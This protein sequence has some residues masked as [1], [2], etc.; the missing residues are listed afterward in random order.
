MRKTSPLVALFMGL[1]YSV[2]AS[3]TDSLTVQNLGETEVHIGA[4]ITENLSNQVVSISEEAWV[5]KNFTAI[6]ILSSYGGIQGHK[7]GGIGS[8]QSISIRGASSRGVKIFIDGVPLEDAG[9]GAV[10]L[11]SID[12]NLVERIDVYKGYVPAF[13]GGNGIGGAIHFISK[14]RVNTG[15]QFSLSYGSHGLQ[16]AAVSFTIPLI[17][18]TRF[19]SSLAYRYSDNDYEFLNRNGTE[20]DTDD[21]FL[22][23]RKNA[24]YLQFSGNHT[25]YHTHENGGFSTLSFRHEKEKGGNPGKESNQTEVAGFNRDLGQVF[26]S[27]EP[28]PYKNLQFTMSLSGQIE[29]SVSHSY[30]PLDKIGFPN[31]YYMEYG[32]IRYF[33]QPKIIV[34]LPTDSSRSWA[35]SLYLA[36]SAERLEDRDNNEWISAYPWHLEQYVVEGASNIQW[37]LTRII[38]LELENAVKAFQNENSGGQWSLPIRNDSLIS[39]SN[40]DLLGSGRLAMHFGHL[41]SPW[42]ASLSLGRYFREPELMEQYGVYRNVLP[43]PDL[44]EET[45]WMGEISLSWKSAS[46]KTKLQSTYFETHQKNG[47]IWVTN[48]SFSKPFNISKA[49]TRGVELSLESKPTSF[50]KTRLEATIQKALDDSSDPL[51]QGK[52]LPE[53]PNTTYHAEAAWLLPYHLEWSFQAGYRSAL[54][55]DRA[56][57]Q[58]IPAQSIYHTYLTWNPFKKTKF[59]LSVQNITDTEYQSIYSS[60]PLPGR[61]FSLTFIQQIGINKDEN[62][63]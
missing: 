10:N 21:D 31:T 34:E 13:L 53:E 51:Y 47:I 6:D 26:Y 36:S 9:G 3:V 5:G 44:K 12:L 42:K 11:G 24:W 41:K 17:S 45:G 48:N 16:E 60:Y 63:Q 46:E 37:F 50:F 14:K 22:V 20:Y 38:S 25:F 40:Q 15:G 32:A 33:L 7:Q 49:I 1:F 4:S 43:N 27:Y 54:Y 56:N 2:S 55:K 18:K 19:A 61:T 59:V 57:R 30:Y 23:K 52:K 28:I 58:R 39:G 29:K 8:F 35:A 62:N